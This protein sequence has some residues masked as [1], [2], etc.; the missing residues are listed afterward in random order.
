MTGLNVTTRID[1]KTL[2][3]RPICSSI[4]RK[5]A[6]TLVRMAAGRTASTSSTVTTLTPSSK[7]FSTHS[8]INYPI[9][10][11]RR[12]QISSSARSTRSDAVTL[13]QMKRRRCATKSSNSSCPKC[14]LRRRISCNIILRHFQITRLPDQINRAPTGLITIMTPIARM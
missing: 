5:G 1:S 8:T 9:A 2:E 4:T 11:R 6:H 12:R 14:F 10:Q 13:T 7:S 3:D